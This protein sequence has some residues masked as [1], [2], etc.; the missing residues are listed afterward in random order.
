MDE[1]DPG[2]RKVLELAVQG[3]CNLFITGPGG[4]GKSKTVKT[5]VE[6]LRARGKK[7]AVVAPTGIAALNIKGK[8]IHS[9]AGIGLGKDTAAS[10]VASAVTRH[11]RRPVR[12]FDYDD[13]MCRFI[14]TDTIVLDEISMLSSSLFAKIDVMAKELRMSRGNPTYGLQ[15]HVIGRIDDQHRP[16]FGGMQVI[17]VGDFFQLPPVD[18]NSDVQFPKCWRCGETARVV[19]KDNRAYACTVCKKEFCGK[20][21]FAFEPDPEGRNR[22]KE[23]GFVFCELTTVHRQK[24]A[25]F[26]AMLHRFRQGSV[27]PEDIASLTH[28]SRSLPPTPDGIVPTKLLPTNEQVNS[29]NSVNYARCRGKEYVYD[30]N[31][32]CIG[33]YGEKL[34]EKA[35]RNCPFDVRVRLKKGAQVM[36]RANLSVEEGLC[37]GTCGAV[38]GFVDIANEQALKECGANVFGLGAA[39]M[40]HRFGSV[41]PI[42]SF[43]IAGTDAP[44]V[45]IIGPQQLT[46]EDKFGGSVSSI[47]ITQVPLI[48]AWAIT[49]HKS[50]GMTISYVRMELARCFDRGQAYV[51]LSRA[52]SMDGLQVESFDPHR[53]FCDEDVIAFYQECRGHMAVE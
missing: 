46:D 47:E 52:A 38:V 1:L 23:A 29:V 32:S 3:N 5:I 17:V 30:M 35:V 18:D 26:V 7:V 16:F 45:T 31:K 48:L 12:K 49:I 25:G 9:W 22:W 24:D 42:V 39:L 43:K 36:L 6:Q 33:K 4:V 21:R 53:I 37:N 10:Y 20:A 8:T 34:L 11:G 13:P 50:Q 28:L 2:Q 41:F 14:N 27:I 40:P 44:F 51:A 15:K 19:D